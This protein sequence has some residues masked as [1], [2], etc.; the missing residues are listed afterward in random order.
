VGLLFGRDQYRNMKMKNCRNYQ[1]LSY[2]RDDV[3]R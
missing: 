1:N 2:A 3:P